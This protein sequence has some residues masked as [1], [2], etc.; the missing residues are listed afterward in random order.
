MTR[1][2][3]QE[4]NMRPTR[5]TS[6]PVTAKS[7]SIKSAGC[8]FS[9]CAL[10]TVEL[11]SGGLPDVSQSESRVKRSTLTVRQKSAAG[12]VVPCGTKA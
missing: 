3:G 9:S 7:A 10:R 6:W 11:T 1:A 2:D 5:R 4:L 12:I 8:K